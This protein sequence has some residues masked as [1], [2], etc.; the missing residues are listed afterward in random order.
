MRCCRTPVSVKND[1]RD[2]RLKEKEPPRGSRGSNCAMLACAHR[3]RQDRFVT[4]NSRFLRERRC[5][6]SHADLGA[7]TRT[8]R[9]PSVSRFRRLSAASG[10]APLSKSST[11][12]RPRAGCGQEGPAAQTSVGVAPPTGSQGQGGRRSAV[13]IP[14]QARFVTCVSRFPSGCPCVLGHAALPA[15]RSGTRRPSVPRFRRVL[16]P[17]SGGDRAGA[18]G[19]GLGSRGAHRGGCQGTAR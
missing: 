2:A 19:D 14:R 6:L 3:S 18:A 10:S 12:A 1:Q 17:Q 9:R 13:Y 8:P 5:V 16:D 11:A 4:R 15:D 7:P